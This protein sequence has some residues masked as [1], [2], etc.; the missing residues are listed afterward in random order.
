MILKD[1]LENILDE[2]FGLHK[3]WVKGYGWDKL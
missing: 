3:L 1:G 2:K